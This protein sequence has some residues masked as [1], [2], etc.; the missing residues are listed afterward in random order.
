MYIDFPLVNIAAPIPGLFGGLD[1]W[2]QG[3]TT[4]R[5]VNNSM[6]TALGELPLNT[7]GLPLS[8]VWGFPAPPSLLPPG[9]PVG[10][11]L[12]ALT[13]GG[14]LAAVAGGPAASILTGP[15]TTFLQQNLTQ[16][17]EVQPLVL[18]FSIT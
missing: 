15:L 17:L 1:I 10:T 8:A 3:Q 2:L 11:S 16:L 5:P 12:G 4:D 13:Q 7:A 18:Y 6:M 14:V 9:V